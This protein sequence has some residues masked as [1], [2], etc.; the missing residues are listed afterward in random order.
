MLP[1]LPTDSFSLSSFPVCIISSVIT[2]L[3][4]TS[5]TDIDWF[6]SW[7]CNFI[8]VLGLTGIGLTFFIAASI[9]LCFEF[10]PKTV[11]YTLELWLLLNL[12]KA[13]S[14]SHPA[15]PQQVGC[16]WARGWEG[17]EP[18]QLARMDIPYHITSC[19]ANKNWDKRRSVGG[20]LYPDVVD[21]CRLAGGEWLLLHHIDFFFFL[22]CITL[23]L[24]STHG[25]SYFCS[26]Y[27]L[28][29]E[30]QRMREQLCGCLCWMCGQPT[31]IL[32]IIHLWLKKY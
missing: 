26:S 4:W 23:S 6:L 29:S 32:D 18:G 15:P 2:R 1:Q 16:G 11:D 30:V 13:F 10:V 12:V 24:I 9:V 20:L 5:G 8:F 22:S 21:A 3:Q 14:A 28:P 7:R 31:T 17:T 25:F 27:S 19:S